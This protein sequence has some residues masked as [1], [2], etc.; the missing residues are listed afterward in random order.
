MINNEAIGI[1]EMTDPIGITNHL[2]ELKRIWQESIGEPEIM[3]AI[4]DGPAD[5]SHPCFEGADI[6]YLG[7]PA[8][9]DAKIAPLFQNATAVAS[10]I[11][12][13]HSSLVPGV[14]PGCRG[15][16]VPVFSD[17]SLSPCS[18]VDLARAIMQSIEYGANIINIIGSGIDFSDNPN[19]PLKNAMR[20]CA[21]N[22]VLL[23][24]AG[25]NEGCQLSSSTGRHSFYHSILPPGERITA[26]APGGG[27]AMKSGTRFVAPIVS[28]IAALLLSIQK[29][30]GEKPDPNFVCEAIL[31]SAHP[32][33]PSGKDSDYRPY[34]A[35][36]LDI[37]S[38]LDYI[39][40]RER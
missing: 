15:L 33:T 16:I 11:F 25:R 36:G 39:R 17:D 7:A 40:K 35:G 6:I 13:R 20:L 18:P 14:A 38:A 26:A 34:P 10:I 1:S 27:V 32:F 24:A 9:R 29:K 3:V 21:K 22:G 30:R 5:L 12:G 19:S 37:A 31:K 4:I 23:V 2:P 28:G 8:S